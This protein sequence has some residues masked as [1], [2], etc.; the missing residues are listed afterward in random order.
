[1]VERVVGRV[2]DEF[3]RVD[4]FEFASVQSSEERTDN[5]GCR[6]ITGVLGLDRSARVV[7]AD[8]EN[9]QRM[10]GVQS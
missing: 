7:L 6:C 1:M 2:D 8:A 3:K 9:R 4:H 10:P 5:D